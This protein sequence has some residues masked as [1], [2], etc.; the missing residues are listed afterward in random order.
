MP[1]S[2]QSCIDT[3]RFLDF[4]RCVF[5]RGGFRE[6]CSDSIRRFQRPSICGDAILWVI[7]LADG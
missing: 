6:I 1:M 2:Y 5:M 7:D 4:E 3:L